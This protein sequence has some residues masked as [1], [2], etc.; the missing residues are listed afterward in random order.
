MLDG[1]DADTFAQNADDVGEYLWRLRS[2]GLMEESIAWCDAATRL[3]ELRR[4]DHA[5]QRTA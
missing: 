2:I 4:P 5:T 1:H 3:I